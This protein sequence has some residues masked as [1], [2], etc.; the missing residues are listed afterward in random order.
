MKQNANKAGN[1]APSPS[2]YHEWASA[3]PGNVA[4]RKKI[5]KSRRS[6]VSKTTIQVIVSGENK[7]SSDEG[8]YKFAGICRSAKVIPPTDNVGPQVDEVFTLAVGGKVTMLNTSNDHLQGEDLVA[9]TLDSPRSGKR[10]MGNLR[11]GIKKFDP[12]EPKTLHEQSRYQRTDLEPRLR[13]FERSYE[14]R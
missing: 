3:F 10:T 13:S 14:H 8:D 2:P 4:L 7:G 9:W 5:N 1:P 6:L 11:I 12:F